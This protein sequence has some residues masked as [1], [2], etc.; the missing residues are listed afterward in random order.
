M[1]K[2]YKDFN[3][4]QIFKGDVLKH[5][6]GKK[7]IVDYYEHFAFNKWRAVYKGGDSGPLALQVDNI[8]R[9]IKTG[10]NVLNNKTN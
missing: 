3:G 6:D 2:L 9:A 10:E 5:P 7:F 8:G 4:E 1:N